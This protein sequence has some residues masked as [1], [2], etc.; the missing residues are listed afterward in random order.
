M[1]VLRKA[2][3][4]GELELPMMGEAEQKLLQAER[5]QQI[6]GNEGG[7]NG[8]FKAKGKGKIEDFTNK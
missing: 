6:G 5:E 7:G 8:G 1:V 2:D 4:F 3:E